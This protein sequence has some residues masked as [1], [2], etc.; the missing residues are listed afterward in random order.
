MQIYTHGIDSVTLVNIDHGK[1][2][3]KLTTQIRRTI[4]LAF[5][6]EDLARGDRGLQIARY[7]KVFHSSAYHIYDKPKTNLSKLNATIVRMEA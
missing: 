2:D 7:L 6:R 5:P 4:F 3:T 1:A